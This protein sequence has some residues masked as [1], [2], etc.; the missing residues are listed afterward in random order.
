METLMKRRKFSIIQIHVHVFF[1]LKNRIVFLIAN[2][3]ISTAA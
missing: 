2:P 3:Y 1:S